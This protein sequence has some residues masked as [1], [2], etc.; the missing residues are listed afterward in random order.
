MSGGVSC[1]L[2]P[3]FRLNGSSLW[4]AVSSFV[5]GGYGG[6]SLILDLSD[7]PWAKIMP[8]SASI[9]ADVGTSL[10]RSAA[11]YQQTIHNTQMR[12]A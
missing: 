4:F 1:G 9:V 8:I 7:R 12:C 5:Q 11:T 3:G 2:V 10:A 6:E